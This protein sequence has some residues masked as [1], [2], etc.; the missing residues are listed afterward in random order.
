MVCGVVRYCRRNQYSSCCHAH[1]STC[2]VLTAL[3]RGCINLSTSALHCGHSRVEGSHS[4]PK[5]LRY[6]AK[7]ALL[8]GG[9]LSAFTT[10]GMPCI[11]NILSNFGITMDSF[12]DLII[13]VLGYLEYLSIM[14]RR[15][16]PDG[17][18]L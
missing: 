1:P 9:P 8:N 3:P 10:D 15:Y 11:A 17:C 4:I 7:S 2:A 16:S 12:I 14:T 5:V 6:L 13:S 18:G